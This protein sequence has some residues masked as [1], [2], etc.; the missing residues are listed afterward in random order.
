[1]HRN[2]IFFIHHIFNITNITEIIGIIEVVTAGDPAVI[3][4]LK[5]ASETFRH[6]FGSFFIQNLSYLLLWFQKQKLHQN[7]SNQN[8]SLL[9]S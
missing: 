7:N 5:M 9:Q 2:R 8:H 4:A 1:M 3:A 6:C